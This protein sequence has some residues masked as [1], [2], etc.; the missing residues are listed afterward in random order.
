MKIRSSTNKLI[1]FLIYLLAFSITFYNIGFLAGGIKINLPLVLI[2]FLDII[3]IIKGKF[4]SMDLLL[5]A[6]FFAVCLISDI[7][8][9]S[10]TSYFPSLAFTMLLILPL[11]ASWSKVNFDKE[12]FLNYLIIG[13]L[14]SMFYIPFELYF[15][16]MHMFGYKGNELW[17]SI[18]GKSHLFF[19]AS[20][21]MLEPSHYTIVL[22]FIYI[23]I[24]IAKDL[25]YSIKYATL[26]KFCFFLTLIVGVSLSGVIMI[27]IYYLLRIL[28][29]AFQSIRNRLKVQINKS[30]LIKIM[31]GILLILIV[32]GLSHNFIGK[33]ASKIHE[34]VLITTNVVEKQKSEGSSGVRSSFIWVSKMYI[35]H[36]SLLNILLG[37]GFAHYRQWLKDNS[38][39]IGYNTGEAYNLFLIILLSIGF[40]GLCSFILMIIGISHINFLVF[41]EIIFLILLFVSFFTH[42]YLIMYWVWTP[43]LFFKI[44]KSNQD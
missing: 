20:S 37:E 15:R 22:F 12:K 9:Y 23:I 31:L 2:L 14:L 35:A 19:R 30:S 38:K 42:G 27:F 26:F 3:L 24:D 8:R 28:N 16:Y 6:F 25:G 21:T 39:K 34:R 7:F 4:Y 29:F 32:N 10:F 33:V 41:N 1:R 17:V 13:A 43:I 5:I 11:G 40:I 44:I 36:A 18:N